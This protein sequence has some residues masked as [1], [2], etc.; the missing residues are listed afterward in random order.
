MV[1]TLRRLSA[2]PHRVAGRLRGRK[3]GAVRPAAKAP[4]VL[5]RNERRPACLVTCS[6][7]CLMVRSSF[8]APWGRYAGIR[9]YS[10]GPHLTTPCV[11]R[12]ESVSR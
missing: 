10:A 6:K 4:V 9:P 8:V 3:N 12:H 5:S 2:P 11:A 7:K 1:L